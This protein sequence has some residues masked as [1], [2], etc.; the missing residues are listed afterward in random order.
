MLLV[1]PDLL[2]GTAALIGAVASLVWSIRRH[3][4]ASSKD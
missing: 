3:P 1:T 2:I 4:K